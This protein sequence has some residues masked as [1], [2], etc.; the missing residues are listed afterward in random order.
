MEE[1]EFK[2][3]KFFFKSLLLE[4]LEAYIHDCGIIFT[5]KKTA[6]VT[7]RDIRVLLIA[8]Y[9]LTYLIFPIAKKEGVYV[10]ISSEE[11]EAQ[12]N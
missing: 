11:T 5:Y 8:Y 12:K 6:L 3:K 2:K 4:I 1:T 10:Y 7:H 9:R